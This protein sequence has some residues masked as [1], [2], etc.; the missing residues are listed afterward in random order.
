MGGGGVAGGETAGL[1]AVELQGDV[2]EFWEGDVIAGGL[3]VF[4][5]ELELRG[6]AFGEGAAG[7]FPADGLG[8]GGRT[9]GQKG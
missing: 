6:L 3:A 2:G 9:E 5:D 1:R 4:E 8:E 7:G